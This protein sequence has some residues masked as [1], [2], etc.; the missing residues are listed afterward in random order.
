MENLI[1]PKQGMFGFCYS[2]NSL[3]EGGGKRC[4]DWVLVVTRRQWN[5]RED[6]EG[7]ERLEDEEEEEEEE[8]TAIYRALKN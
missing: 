3:P 6:S 5:E 4:S 1:K 8:E 7:R 2:G